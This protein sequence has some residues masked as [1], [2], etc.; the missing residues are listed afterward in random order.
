MVQASWMVALMALAIGLTISSCGA[1]GGEAGAVSRRS[2]EP[3]AGDPAGTAVSVRH[4]AGKLIEDTDGDYDSESKSRYDADDAHVLDYGQ[5]AN[6][7][8]R[9]KVTTV[10]KR[11]FAAVAAENGALAC[12]LTYWV[13]A[14]TIPEEYGGSSEQNRSCA[15]VASRLFKRLHRRYADAASLQVTGVRVEGNRGLALLNF[16]TMHDRHIAVHREGRTWRIYVLFDI[17]LS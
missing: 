17:G 5:A 7:E 2:S 16:K 10:V 11:Y 6:A 1:A 3:G 8:D 12:S 14:E 13:V 4:G 9:Y 15:S